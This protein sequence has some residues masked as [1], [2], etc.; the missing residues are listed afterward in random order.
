MGVGRDLQRTMGAAMGCGTK[1]PS[2]EDDDAYMARY[3]GATSACP[4]FEGE[5]LETAVRAEWD[6]ELGALFELW[7]T[8]K[9]GSLEVGEIGKIVA[10]YHSEPWD[11]W[12]AEERL[13]YTTDF[14]RWYDK[15]TTPDN[16]LSKDELKTFIVTQAC[17]DDPKDP[18]EA[19]GI[20]ITK[21]TDLIKKARLE[22]LFVLWD[23]DKSGF[24][25]KGEFNRIVAIYNDVDYDV[26][27]A[28]E[29]EAKADSLIAKMPDDD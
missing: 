2:N 26:L 23:A 22:E 11:T 4:A 20:I 1:P 28:A 7:D 15:D 29:K 8:D 10:M 9:S 27:T 13:A 17:V 3:K 16:K 12:S 14:M 19:M 18:D 6:D 25:E 5:C 24:L 21:M